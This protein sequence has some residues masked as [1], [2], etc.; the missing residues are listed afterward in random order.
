MDN[1]DLVDL[2][3]KRLI[4][5]TSDLLIEVLVAKMYG[6]NKSDFFSIVSSFDYSESEVETLETF[7]ENNK[8]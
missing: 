4:N 2:V 1:Y 8:R 5:E 7:W 6:L 3:N